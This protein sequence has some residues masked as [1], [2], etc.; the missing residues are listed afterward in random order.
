MIP[1]IDE[2]YGHMAV[3]IGMV[4]HRAFRFGTRRSCMFLEDAYVNGESKAAVNYSSVNLKP[5]DLSRVEVTG[6]SIRE[7]QQ[8]EL[9]AQ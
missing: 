8:L 4:L 7:A 9:K 5:L 6:N 1:S 3:M 2:L